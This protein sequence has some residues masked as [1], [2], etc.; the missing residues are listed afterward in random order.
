MNITFLGT[1]TSH[2][3]PPLDCMI[4]NYAQCPQN[5]CRMSLIDPK[6]NRTRSSLYIETDTCTI[7]VDIS[8]D[9]R[10]QA[11]R[12][13]IKR[14]DF[15]LITH[16]HADHVGGIPDIRSYTIDRP[17]PLYA[18]EA[19][20]KQIRE[21]FSYIFDPMTFVG[22]GIPS[23]KTCPVKQSFDLDSVKITPINVHHGNVEGCF[24]YRIG[25][26]AYIPDMKSIDKTEFDKLKGLDLL[27]LNC[28][29]RG[30]EHSTHLILP[31]SIELARKIKPA[32]C[33]FVHMSHDI[34]YQYDAS[35]LDSWMQFSY[36]GL[37]VKV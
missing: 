24:G 33:Y 27:I 25:S 9:F 15:A 5:V 7:I 2:G 18:S 3:V 21:T 11:L 10:Q 20:V 26:I 19:T 23:I 34:H 4:N 37:K 6:H 29:R 22:G 14:I 31:E 8:E 36:D 35:M 16:S 28:L 12:E 30:R 1:G 32:F 17:L 13:Q